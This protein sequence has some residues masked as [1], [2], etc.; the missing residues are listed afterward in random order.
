MASFYLFLLCSAIL[1]T[2][3]LLRPHKHNTESESLVWSNPLESLRSE[4][5]KGIGNY[6]LLAILLFVI[7]VVLYM[8]F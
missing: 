4:D 7:M 2:V 1:V 8:I 6:K 5:W 3:S